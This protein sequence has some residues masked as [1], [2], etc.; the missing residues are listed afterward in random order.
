MNII[1]QHNSVSL[2]ALKNVIHNLIASQYLKLH[3]KLSHFTQ[4][5]AK[6]IELSCNSYFNE[7]GA[8]QRALFDS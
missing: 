1:N 7:K 6:T 3:I 4:I 2:D 8:W 5:L